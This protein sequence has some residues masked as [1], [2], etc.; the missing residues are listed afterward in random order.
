MSFYDVAGNMD[1][2]SRVELLERLLDTDERLD[3]NRVNRKYSVGDPFPSLGVAANIG[4][5]NLN[6]PRAH[7]SPI[8][9]P[10]ANKTKPPKYEQLRLNTSSNDYIVCKVCNFM[11][12]ETIQ[13]EVQH[14]AREH[15]KHTQ[16][17]HPAN[18]VI[19][20][21]IWERLYNEGVHRIH[22]NQRRAGQRERAWYEMALEI[23]RE[24]G[25]AGS[26]DEE[27]LWDEICIDELSPQASGSK[28]EK[29]TM[30]KPRKMAPRYKVYVY[31]INYEV[32]SVA[33]AQRITKA[34]SYYHGPQTHDEHGKLESPHS[35][36]FQQYVDLD[37]SFPVQ[38]SIDCL[39]TAS[40]HQRKGYATTL[41]DQLRQD[42]IWGVKVNKKHVAISFPTADG[43]IFARGY[44]KS[45]FEGCPFV[46]ADEA[47]VVLENGMLR[48]GQL[49][50]K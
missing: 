48:T 9:I 23:A 16:P 21:Q 25:L 42:F 43:A 38:V 39:C 4:P 18:G 10:G 49:V 24:A 12:N 50:K 35:T 47:A 7:S 28:Y 5:V 46:V 30:T 27:K 3:Q 11:Y 37:R 14:H 2:D 45:V 32:V 36:K 8:D 31:T 1:D 6:R 20:D 33:L 22:V 40:G 44:F 15:K 29:T 26:Y 17:Q 34:G 19:R 13:A 41:L